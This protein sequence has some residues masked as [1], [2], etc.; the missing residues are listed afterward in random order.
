MYYFRYLGPYKL[1]IELVDYLVL[2]IRKQMCSMLSLSGENLEKYEE[3]ENLINIA[4][5]N[6][7]VM[8]SSKYSAGPGMVT[9]S[10]NNLECHLQLW[11]C[12]AIKH[13]TDQH[14]HYKCQGTD[15]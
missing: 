10:G 9:K 7:K 2:D 14:C 8:L 6:K 5:T 1:G 4:I 11:E 15:L 3:G 13:H 12:L